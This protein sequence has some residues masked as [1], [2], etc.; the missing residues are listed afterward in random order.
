MAGQMTRRDFVKAGVAIG[1]GLAASATAGCS[2]SSPAD[3][4]DVDTPSTSYGGDGQMDK[5]V[6]VGYA[7]RTGSTVGV[8]EEIGKT[9]GERGLSVDVK[10]LEER[11]SLEGY[12]AVVLGSAINGGRWL[13]EAKEYVAANGSALGDIP[14]CLFCVH[15]MNTEDKERDRKKRMAYIDEIR[16]MVDPAEEGYF[17]GVGL[18]PETTSGFERWAFKTFGGDVEGDGR[19]WDAVRS[20]A[21]QLPVS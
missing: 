19:D 11:P 8:A 17:A 10:P 13:P 4:A 18:D 7:T 15:A 6:L 3:E 16:E 9:L 21:E 12:D 5:R 1:A 14:V 2:M 20:W